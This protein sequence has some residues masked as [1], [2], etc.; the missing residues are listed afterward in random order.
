MRRHIGKKVEDG[1]LEGY[2]RRRR[3]RCGGGLMQIRRGSVGEKVASSGGHHCHTVD[4]HVIKV[5]GLSSSA[6]HQH[7]VTVHDASLTACGH[8]RT[9]AIKILS[10]YNSK[11]ETLKNPESKETFYLTFRG[12][13][14]EMVIGNTTNLS[15]E[16]FS[17][18]SSTCLRSLDFRLTEAGLCLLVSDLS[19]RT[20]AS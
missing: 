9:P 2:G 12:K 13:T 18:S 6:Q 4:I 7:R 1:S 10:L 17:T 11:H 15:R 14:F 20:A 8:W 16:S 19:R 5:D 3:G